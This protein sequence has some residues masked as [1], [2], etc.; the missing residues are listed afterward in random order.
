[1]R[2]SVFATVAVVLGLSA[3]SAFAVPLVPSGVDVPASAAEQAQASE[4]YH[5][6]C[7]WRDG[8]WVVN[9]GV[10]R[11]VLCRPNRPGR[12]WRWHSDGPRHGWYNDRRRAWH[13]NRW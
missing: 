10:G 7:R 2:T 13:N 9:L 8:R 12:D 5:R 4:R 3:S 11:V 6:N 1:M